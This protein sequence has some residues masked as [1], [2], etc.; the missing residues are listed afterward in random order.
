MGAGRWRR[1]ALRQCFE[2]ALRRKQGSVD[3]A[4]VSKGLLP[5]VANPSSP[6][7]NSPKY[8]VRH[9]SLSNS[10]LWSWLLY[11]RDDEEYEEEY[12]RANYDAGGWFATF[13]GLVVVMLP[14][15]GDGSCSGYSE[16]VP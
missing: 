1:Q 5:G 4:G 10:F 12:V 14:I 6:Y 8:G 13:G 16:N 9:V 3:S 7:Y 15:G 2:Q 11:D